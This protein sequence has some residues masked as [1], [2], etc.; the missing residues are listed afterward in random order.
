MD[1][2]TFEP[3]TVL[4]LVEARLV[5][6]PDAVAVEDDAGKLSYEQLWSLATR[7][8]DRLVA[9]GCGPGSPVAV[10]LP[11]GR[12][13]VAI[14]LAA[15]LTGAAY[16]P[17]DPSTPAE[18]VRVVTAKA[19]CALLARD[20]GPG[21]GP[22]LEPVG[23]AARP[24][25]DGY[26]D[27]AYIVFTSGSTGEPKGVAVGHASLANLVAWHLAT[28][29]LGPADRVTAFAG[30]GFD[31]SVWEIWSTLAAGAALVLPLESD[32]RDV[33]SV[34]EHIAASST[35][36][37]FLS[38]P[39]AERLLRTPNRPTSLRLLLTGGDRLHIWPDPDFPA[40]VH[41][42]Y[43]PT[44]ATVV[45]TATGDLRRMTQ[46]GLPPIGRGVGGAEL[47]LVDAAGR[48]VTAPGEPGELWIGGVI[49][50]LGYVGPEAGADAFVT[51][52]GAGR[53][54]RSGDLC[55]WD[56]AGELYFVGRADRQVKLRGQR[57]E[58][59]EIEQVLCGVPGVS[60]AAVVVV[61]R[62][63]DLELAAFVVGAVGGVPAGH[64]A[65]RLP[66]A[67]VPR[68]VETC[69][70]LPLTPNGKIDYAELTR[71]AAA[72]EIVPAA[73]VEQEYATEVERVIA[74]IWARVLGEPTVRR[75]DDFFVIG[76]HSMTASEVVTEVRTTFQI[77]LHLRVL[78]RFPTLH[79][80]SAQ[81]EALVSPAA[82]AKDEV[83]NR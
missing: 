74:G 63:G 23:T 32:T 9:G 65:D 43:G 26:A 4:A 8:A 5:E 40:A 28:Y 73:W 72:A 20:G 77:P 47:R 55:T 52:A 36:A 18:R 68:R 27:V 1:T 33:D 15:W 78:L 60:Q 21:H 3:R 42:H 83:D 62:Q 16:V 14:E 37:C 69:D 49:V 67:M 24:G 76:G 30:T 29:D 53:W 80:F 48:T 35:T 50:A 34:A 82:T 38:T 54:Y 10:M 75:D 57:I 59:G 71:R 66:A 39:L 31:A 56:A 64:L 12:D 61:D 81:I 70:A 25:P 17:I 58:L 79:E 22:T 13:Q 19:N 41:N 44:E 2:E 6:A 7:W 11:R 46:D 45:T 51:E